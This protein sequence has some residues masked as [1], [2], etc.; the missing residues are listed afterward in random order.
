MSRYRKYTLFVRVRNSYFSS[1]VIWADGRILYI[2]GTVAYCHLEYGPKQ[3]HP[4]APA[5]LTGLCAGQLTLQATAEGSGSLPGNGSEAAGQ[6]TLVTEAGF[7][8]DLH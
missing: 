5:M 8:G 7:R 6:V 3:L 1:A 2:R 4:L